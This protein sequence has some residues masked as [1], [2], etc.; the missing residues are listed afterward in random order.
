LLRATRDFAEKDAQFAVEVGIESIKAL[1]SGASYELPTGLDVGVHYEAVMTVACQHGMREQA[2]AELAKVAC[3][4]FG[5]RLLR[6]ALVRKLQ[7]NP[8]PGTLR[9]ENSDER[10][11]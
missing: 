8:P 9:R 6:E 4:P 5:D 2:K 1:L 11:V 3:G 7:Q 10:P